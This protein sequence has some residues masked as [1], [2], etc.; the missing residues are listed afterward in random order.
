MF[1]TI[2]AKFVVSTVVFVLLSVGIPTTFLVIQFR[3][4]F[5]QRSRIMLESTLDVVH[6]ALANAMVLGQH[7][8]E[9]I[10]YIVDNISVNPSVDH[11]RIITPDGMV[12][13]ATDT[14]EIGKKMGQ[15]APGHFLISSRDSIEIIRYNHENVYSMIRP[16]NNKPECL[17]CHG[18]PGSVIAYVDVDTDLTRAERYFYTGSI[19][20]IFLAIAILLIMFFGFYFIFNHYIRKPL[21]NFRTALDRVE[22]GNL[23]ISLPAEKRD[24]I[25][26]LEGHFNQMVQNLKD[27]KNQIEA[28]HFEQLQRADKMVTLGELAAEMAHEINNPAGIIMSRTDY[29]QMIIQ[30]NSDYAQYEEDIEVILKQVQKISNITGNILKYSRKLPKNF[31]KLDLADIIEE[32]LALLGPRLSKKKI[33]VNTS[34][35][36][37]PA[38]INGDA[39]QMEQVLTNLINNAIDAMQTGGSL[40]I[41]LERAN[42]RLILRV[43]DDGNGMDAETRA[44]IF[45]PF[46]TTK[47]GDKGTGLGLYIVRNILKNHHATIDCQSSPGN[48]TT[49]EIMFN[50][51]V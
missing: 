2:H 40:N 31:Q 14:S 26:V 36:A 7:E 9:H 20:M 12:K 49:F 18:D 27:S 44:N 8:R 24:E 35:S 34:I 50:K 25:G 47:S 28:M 21:L 11:I 32:T 5:D 4:N 46:F 23:N 38:R 33:T 43:Q 13:Y 51:P 41:S 45:S 1:K 39:M 3:Q 48:G 10:Q 42:S 22:A 19:H 6:G 17:S 15:I 37:D 29:L 30:K 16:V